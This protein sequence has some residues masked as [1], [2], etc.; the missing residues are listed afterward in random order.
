METSLSWSTVENYRA[1][2]IAPGSFRPIIRGAVGKHELEAAVGL[3]QQ[4][5][6]NLANI[7][8]VIMA[9]KVRSGGRQ[10]QTHEANE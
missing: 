10:S 3:Q 2:L 4:L 1:I 6:S 8:Q 7:L 5:R 9:V